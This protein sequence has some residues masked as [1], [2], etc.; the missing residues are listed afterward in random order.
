LPVSL[1]T[2]SD[3]S[4]WATTAAASQI[5]VTVCTLAPYQAFLWRADRRYASAL[6]KASVV[7]VDGNGVRL[8]LSV[9]GVP[10]SGRLTGRE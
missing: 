6:L 7:L 9:A 5:G 2:W 1:L 4:E 10:A 3:L 8:A